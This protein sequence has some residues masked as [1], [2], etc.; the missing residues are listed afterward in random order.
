MWKGKMKRDLCDRT[1]QFASRVVRLCQGLDEKPGVARTLGRQLL[2]SGTSIGANVEEGQGGQSRAD[3]VS[4]YSIA[5]KEARETNY[6][7]RLLAATDIV[8]EAKLKDLLEESNQLVA[9]LTTIIKNK[10]ERKMNSSA[11]HSSYFTL[12]TSKVIPSRLC[13]KQGCIMP[14]MNEV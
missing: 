4:K 5:C 13:C 7:L 1:F 10:G 14:K 6:W 12:L 9:I 11:F 3:F 8:P 2:R